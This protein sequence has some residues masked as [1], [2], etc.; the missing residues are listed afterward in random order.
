MRSGI[1]RQALRR[2]RWSL[3]GPAATAVLGACVISVMMMTALGLSSSRLS[4]A[5]YAKVAATDLPDSTA[6]FLAD[7]I[8]LSIL[9]AGVTMNLAITRQLRDVALLRMIGA[10]PSQIRRSVV[11]QAAIVAVPSA[12][13]GFL[14]AIPAG[15]AWWGLLRGHGV[16]PD[17]VGFAPSLPALPAAAGIELAASAVGAFFA[18]VRVGW[19]SPL[20]AL[21]E[22]A[23]GRRGAGRLRVTLGLMLISAGVAG[24]IVLSRFAANEAGQAAVFVLL[25]ESAG[26][27]M[28]VPAVLRI[29][30]GLLRW[31]ARRGPTRVAVDNVAVL[32]RSL[33]GALIPLVL[34]LAFAA[35]K[36]AVHTTAG[37]GAAI[38]DEAADPWTDYSGT[39]VFFAFAAVAAVNAL[40]TVMAGRRRDLATLRLAGGD[41]RDVLRVVAIEAAV[42]TVTALLLAAGVAGATLAPILHTSVHVWVP[43]VPV[44]LVAAGVAVAG[45]LVAAGMLIPAAVLTR[46]APVD[47]AGTAA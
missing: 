47:V 21:T 15:Y 44:Y 7:S 27:G 1:T 19:I 4:P 6:V 34:A 29:T 23:A 14:V 10:R 43:Y 46:R 26:A 3:L 30:A 33:S 12:A 13:V 28:I 37:S 9:I 16:V 20:A 22:A 17:G 32:S 35:V 2:H 40:I 5:T 18:S 24:S 45:G 38:S 36:V 25:A 42:V 11:A 31:F 39:V 41:R 8:Y